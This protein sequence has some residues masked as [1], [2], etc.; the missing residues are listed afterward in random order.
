MAGWAA[1]A[2]AAMEVGA[3]WMNSSAQHKANRTNIRLQREQQRWEENMANTA[4]QRRVRDIQLAGGNPAAAFVSG[5]EA[6]TPTLAPARVDPPSYRAPSLNSA[7]LLKAQLD[8]I[9]ADTFNKSADTRNKTI[10]GDVAKGMFEGGQVELELEGKRAGVEKLREEI[11]NT[12]ERSN[13]T[14]KQANLLE[15]TTDSLVQAA[16][17]Q[18]REGKLNLDALENIAAI[19]GIEAAKSAPLLKLLK[20]FILRN[21]K[22]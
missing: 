15:K 21:M 11:V 17:Q 19:G 12:A 6:A 4:V 10:A 22:D 9:K 2:Q 16:Q 3:S 14:A 18:A 5:G 8:N 7:A 13:L 20:D 1:A